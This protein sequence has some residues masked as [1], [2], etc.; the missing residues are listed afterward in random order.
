MSKNHYIAIMCCFFVLFG[1]A[2]QQ[3]QQQ[4]QAN[5]QER[6]IKI[7][8][9]EVDTRPPS[10]NNIEPTNGSIFS[11]ATQN[12]TISGILTDASDISTMT[13]NSEKVNFAQVAE[14]NSLKIFGFSTSIDLKPGTNSFILH[15]TDQDGNKYEHNF[16]YVRKEPEFVKEL[17][18]K[19]E[20]KELSLA[21]TTFVEVFAI[22]G[23]QQRPLSAS[24]VTLKA[25]QGY[26]SGFEYHAPA[27]GGMDVITATYPEQKAKGKAYLVIHSPRLKQEISGPNNIQIGKTGAFK[28]KIDNPGD[29]DAIKAR[30]VIKLPDFLKVEDANKGRLIAAVNE[31]HWNLDNISA[32]ASKEIELSVRAL[33]AQRG[34]ILVSALSSKEEIIKQ[35]HFIKVTGEVAVEH[36]CTPSIAEIEKEITTHVQVT[37]N[38]DVKNVKLNYQFSDECVFVDAVVIAEGTKIGFANSGKNVQFSSISNLEKG[39]SIT[40]KLTFLVKRYGQMNN[41]AT[42]T[43]LSE[44]EEDVSSENTLTIPTLD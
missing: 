8:I 43:L 10:L 42:V 32:G 2:C 1:L 28:V 44:R 29:R 7:V 19:P 40:Y 30:I 34:K 14:E 33:R 3:Q 41:I 16:S 31:V 27:Y 18:V 35:A 25:Q 5:T 23:E 4:Q 9:K 22:D 36:F 26:F 21:G 6:E 20:V 12:I 24:E 13:L 15:A 17:I 37:A 39:K 11:H 38:E